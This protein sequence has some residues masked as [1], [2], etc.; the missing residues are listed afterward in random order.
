LARAGPGGPAAANAGAGVR[1]T[2]KYVVNFRDITQARPSLW[3]AHDACVH[4][5]VNSTQER[6]RHIFS[7][8]RFNNP[9]HL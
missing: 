3:R 4:M 5:S 8:R 9:A 2:A 1:P 6:V 7:L